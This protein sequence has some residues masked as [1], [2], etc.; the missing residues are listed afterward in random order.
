MELMAGI[1]PF[2]FLLSL[3]GLV[4]WFYF[5]GSNFT[6][7][8]SRMFLFSFII[9]IFALALSPGSVGFK[10][11]ILSRDFIFMAFVV[12]A[13]QFLS[14]KKVLYFG[15]M[16]VFLSIF[17][18]VLFDRLDSTFKRVPTLANISEDYELI[19]GANRDFE[20]SG[21]ELVKN[22]FSLNCRRMSA[23]PYPGST[24]SYL[25]VCNVPDYNR[26]RLD[27]I[28]WWLER[29]P[30][31]DWYE[32]NQII[33]VDPLESSSYDL[34]TKEPPPG[35]IVNDPDI[36]KM[37]HFEELEY[38]QLH[39]LLAENEERIIRRSLISILDTGIDHLHEDI[40]ENYHSID[41]KYDGD[42]MGHGTHCAGIS[43]AVSNNQTGIAG[44]SPSNLHYNVSS[45]RVL[46]ERGF[47]TKKQIIKGI[48]Q[49]AEAE[50]DVISLSLGGP[51]IRNVNRAYEEAVKFALNS[52]SIVVVAAGN[53]GKP[54]RNFSPANVKGVICVGSVDPDGSFSSFSNTPLGIEKFI[55][56]PG[57]DIYSTLP[58]DQYAV[59]SGTSM[60]TPIVA[61]TAAIAKSIQPNITAE[62]FYRLLLETAEPVNGRNDDIRAIRP[63]RAIYEL[64][65]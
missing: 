2:F 47:G 30:L 1:Y 54:A 44:Q 23:S 43:A 34:V 14:R 40:S 31:V 46:N 25:M 36:N 63:Y 6:G 17:F 48:F 26:N 18:S 64:L 60:A 24:T 5:R 62:E 55:A 56:A 38:P 45:I 3:L 41:E 37:W 58:G 51:S 12:T 35:V 27:Q 29:S 15:A 13:F 49:A 53:A 33:Q 4:G 42:P 61:A 7:L 8:M 65:K 19:I 52:G 59:L 20:I 32:W 39:R 21:L 22:R 9:Y 16:I 10:L 57:R 28:S 50:A 11:L